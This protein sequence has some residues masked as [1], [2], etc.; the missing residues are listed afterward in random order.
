MNARKWNKLIEI[1]EGDLPL[2]DETL[3]ELFVAFLARKTP[4]HLALYRE[5]DFMK[6]TLETE[7]NV[8]EIVF[9]YEEEDEE[10]PTEISLH[11]DCV[12]GEYVLLIE[13]EEEV[14][15]IQSGDLQG[16]FEEMDEEDEDDEEEDE[17]EEDEEEEEDEENDRLDNLMLQQGLEQL[18]KHKK[19]IY[20]SLR[21][22]EKSPERSSTDIVQV[23]LHSALHN[24][25]AEGD[26]TVRV[27]DPRT[28]QE[29]SM[30]STFSKQGMLYQR[31]S[32][33]PG[34]M[35]SQLSASFDDLF[36]VEVDD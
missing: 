1:L 22:A 34:K 12:D 9:P 2:M 19:E 21:T 7:N 4:I 13:E 24:Q 32:Y 6:A 27:I 3:E 33:L 35:M 15:R 5:G 11:G 18:K 8:R 25:P 31:E 26:W 23:L 20:A 28:G 14:T 17:D 36:E 16:L 30:S 10:V 29:V